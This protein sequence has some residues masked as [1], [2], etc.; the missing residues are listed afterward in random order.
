[1]DAKKLKEVME[2]Q[3]LTVKALAVEIGVTP[4]AIYYWL[5]GKRKIPGTV[6][7]IFKMKF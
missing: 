5:N 7:V 6:E 3:K 4:R 1:M 2:T